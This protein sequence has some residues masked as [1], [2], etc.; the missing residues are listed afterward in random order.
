MFKYTIKVSLYLKSERGNVHDIYY[1][2]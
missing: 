1:K 2:G